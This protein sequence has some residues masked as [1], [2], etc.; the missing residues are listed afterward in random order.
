MRRL[1]VILFVVGIL[2]STG[3]CTLALPE[4]LITD[5]TNIKCENASRNNK[6]DYFPVQV[7][8]PWGLR[9]SSN[10]IGDNW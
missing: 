8:W 6:Q 9:R 10:T 1:L 5:R 2:S 3:G 7:K 4:L